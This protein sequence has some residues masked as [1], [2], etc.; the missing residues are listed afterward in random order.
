M[1]NY[2][3]RKRTDLILIHCSATKPDHDISIDDVRTW[4]VKKGWIDVGYHFLIK[5]NGD[6]EIG[7]PHDVVGSH[8]RGGNWKSIGICLVG[9]LDSEGNPS[10]AYNQEQ[11]IALRALIKYLEGLYPDANIKGHYELD[12]N[13]ECPCVT[14]EELLS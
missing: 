11:L 5:L 14:V 6:V 2:K 9:G 3:T 13:K 4:H 7:R 1:P 12:D 8:C 10:N